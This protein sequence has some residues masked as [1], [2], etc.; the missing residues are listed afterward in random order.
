MD[1]GWN[2]VTVK[3]REDPNMDIWALGLRPMGPQGKKAE[4]GGTLAPFEGDR[5]KVLCQGS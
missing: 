3:E 1:G 2:T 4:L 5:H